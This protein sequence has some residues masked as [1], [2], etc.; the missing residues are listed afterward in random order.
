MPARS[1]EDV[2]RPSDVRVHEGLRS[3]VGIRDGDERGQMEDDVDAF[4]DGLHESSITHVA[5]SHLERFADLDLG[6]VQPPP[7]PLR[8]VE[9]ERTHLCAFADEALDQVTTD[10]AARPGDQ[11]PGSF[12]AL[13]G[14]PPRA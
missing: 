4:A 2:H 11:D 13:H 7:G 6:P 5:E 8:V 3:L 12:E 14:S 1:L 9:T 10:E